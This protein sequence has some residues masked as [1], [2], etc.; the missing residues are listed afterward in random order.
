MGLLV[1]SDCRERLRLVVHFERVD[2][3]LELP[4]YA[5]DSHHRDCGA[6]ERDGSA[7]CLIAV[8]HAEVDHTFGIVLIGANIGRERV[9]VEHQITRFAGVRDDAALASRLSA[10]PAPVILTK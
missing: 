7:G 2:V 5:A 4:G 3:E 8:I 6:V 9:E 1:H 10:V